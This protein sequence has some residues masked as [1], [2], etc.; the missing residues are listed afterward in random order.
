MKARVWMPDKGKSGGYEYDMWR[1]ISLCYDDKGNCLKTKGGRIL[2]ECSGLKDRDGQ[3]IF[4]GD[5][6]EDI[7]LPVTLEEGC[8]F[9]TIAYDITR[10]PLYKA[11]PEYLAEKKFK[12]IGNRHENP[13]LLE[14]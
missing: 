10:I 12:V 14:Q 7:D 13:K 11:K 5:I 4:V 2:E 9:G 8:F 1:V 3:D 6:L